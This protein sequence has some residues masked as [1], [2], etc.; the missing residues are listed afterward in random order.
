MTSHHHVADSPPTNNSEIIDTVIP[1]ITYLRLI[2][3]FFT[4]SSSFCEFKVDPNTNLSILTDDPSGVE[5][6]ML[7]LMQILIVHV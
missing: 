3:T 2:L 6:L 1:R 4:F 5:R 7:S